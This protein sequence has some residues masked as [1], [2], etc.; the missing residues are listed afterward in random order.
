MR[1]LPLAEVKQLEPG[2]IVEATAGVI[3]EIFPQKS[4][5]NRFGDWTLQKMFL[6]DDSGA[7]IEVKL[8][9]HGAF[10]GNCLNHRLYLIAA[11]GK[12]GLTGLRTEMD[13]YNGRNELILAAEK[14]VELTFEA[15]QAST[16][17]PAARSRATRKASA[18]GAKWKK[19]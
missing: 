4:G 16:T 18:L 15:P 6:A 1:I 11:Q 19:L 17:A 14:N 13:T 10:E 9:N 5:K 2:T 8:V 7:R 12:K 3:V